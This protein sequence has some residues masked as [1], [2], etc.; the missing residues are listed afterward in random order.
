MIS[1][2]S[3]EPGVYV[4]RYGWNGRSGGLIIGAGRMTAAVA[5]FVPGVRVVDREAGQLTGPRAGHT[6][7]KPARHRTR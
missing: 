4:P 3:P 7:S 6:S 5:H 1:D 2:V